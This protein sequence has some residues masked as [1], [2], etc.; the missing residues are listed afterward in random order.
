MLRTQRTVAHFPLARICAIATI[1]AAMSGCAVTPEPA[2]DIESRLPAAVA[3]DVISSEI[4]LLALGQLGV[5][6][7]YGGA[8]PQQGFDCSGL[9]TYVY[10]EAT[11]TKLP[12]TTEELA[13]EGTH[14]ERDELHPGDLVFYDTLGRRFSHVG[15]YLGEGKFVHSPSRNGVVRVEDMRVSYWR[16]RYTGARR[17]DLPGAQ[18]AER[19]CC[20]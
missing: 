11:G 16:E 9:V 2:A 14:V 8:S 13:G 1:V 20:R 12:R 3:P 5:P 7:R 6:Y 18:T 19:H 15:I 4:A 10:R 17:L